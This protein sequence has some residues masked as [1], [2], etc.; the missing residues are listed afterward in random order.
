MSTALAGIVNTM[1]LTQSQTKCL[2]E[3]EDTKGITSDEAVATGKHIA[4]N[5]TFPL[6]ETTKLVSATESDEIIVL[7]EG[8][9]K[10]RVLHE[11]TGP[12]LGSHCKAGGK[13]LL[14][15]KALYTDGRV[16]DNSRASGWPPF[17]LVLGKSFKLK[18][19]E[20]AVPTMRLGEVARIECSQ[21]AA[22]PY[23]QFSLVQRQ[24]HAVPESNTPQSHD[25]AQP[26]SCVEKQALA[27]ELGDGLIEILNE[28]QLV[29]ELEVVDYIAPHTYKEEFWEID[30]EEKIRLIPFHA[31]CA[32]RATRWSETAS[33]QKP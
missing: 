23:P 8:I 29:F 22:S 11:G 20:L 25:H 15:F 10:I 32:R 19:W 5:V 28:D 3:V 4:Q 9:C 33:T 18:A 7:D 27:L 12:E 13:V 16:I 6:D 1:A 26:H 31:D 21:L 17:D 2:G 30:V 24:R 14:H